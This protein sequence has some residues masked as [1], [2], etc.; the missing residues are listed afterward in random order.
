VA[1][2]IALLAAAPA[3]AQDS[4]APPGADVNWLPREDWVVRHWIPFDERELYAAL[5]VSRMDVFHWL[6]SHEH[7]IAGLARRRGVSPAA[8]VDR[9]V[10]RWRG[11][12][13]FEHYALL[14][15]R[16]R[17]TMTQSHLARHL[18]FHVFHN[19]RIGQNAQFFFGVDH[20]TWWE[21]RS[22][23]HTVLEV[24][25]RGGRTETSVRERLLRFLAREQR[26]GVKRLLTPKR[27]AKRI[28]GVQRRQLVKW[29]RD[30]RLRVPEEH[31]H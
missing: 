10:R 12:A 31:Q 27:Q 26:V 11:R 29:L 8:L 25:R 20:R 13:G 24:A 14:R 19:K 5:R 16:T 7:T 22:S 3:R 15:S 4:E 6:D 9:L 2:L 21:M 28:L 18:L 17:R 1:A 30:N 23:G